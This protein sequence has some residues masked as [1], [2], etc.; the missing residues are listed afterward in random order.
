MST[1]QNTDVFPI[2]RTG[3]NYQVT[4]ADLAT[5]FAGGGAAGADVQ[6][7]AANPSFRSD[8]TSA[9]V[10]GDLYYNT[11][12]DTI[13][14]YNGTAWV[15]A[16]PQFDWQS[17][18][19]NPT[20]LAIATRSDG[21]A[22]LVD[23]DMFW[24]NVGDSLHAWD[25]AAWVQASVKAATAA[26][27]ATGTL[28]TVY[29]SPATAVPKDDAGMTGAAIIPGGDDTER[30]A[31]TSPVAGM[32]RYNDTTTPAVMEYYDGSNWVTLSTGGADPL[33]WFGHVL[34]PSI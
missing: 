10:E 27:A 22:A 33:G 25:G 1:V 2:S 3:T 26:E 19:G 6:A 11:T 7:A 34:I 9:L 24:D 17:G 12:D 4:A 14:A 23:G 31:I 28:T 21:V 8:G 30:A 32:L 20:T 15:K 16:A 5:F 18:A 29:S 13:Y